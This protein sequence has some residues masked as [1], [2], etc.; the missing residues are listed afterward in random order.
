MKHVGQ[1]HN[2][3]EGPHK[4]QGA[5]KYAAE[6]HEEGLLHGVIVS[7][8]IAKGTIR[9]IDDSKAAKVPGVVKI[10]TH[11]NRPSLAWFDRS[12][13]DQDSPKG[14]HFRPLYD[15]KILFNAQPIALVVAENFEVARYAATLLH[16]E[17]ETAEHVTDLEA[18]RPNAKDPGKAKQGYVPPPKPKGD[19][20]KAWKSAP[21]KMKGSYVCPPEHHNPMEL[22]ATTVLVDKEGKYTVYD[23]TQGVTNS[24]DYVCNVFGLSKKE[25]RVLCPYMGGGFGSGLRPQYQLFLAIMAAKEL[26]QS[27]RVSMTRQQMFSFGHRPETHFHIALATDKNG[28]LLA[29]EQKALAETSTFET[30]AENLV[31]WPTL[32]YKCD[33][34][35]LEHKIAELDVFTPLDMRAPG[36]AWSL[37]VFEMAMDEMAYEAEI[38][39]IELRLANYT[40]KDENEKKPYTSKN[41]R[42][43]YSEGAKRFGWH[44]RNPYPRSMKRNGQLVGYGMATGAWDSEQQKAAIKVLLKQDGTAEVSSG[45]TD[46]GTGT[47]TIMTQIA[48]DNLGLKMAD[49]KF[50]LGDS[51]LPGAPLQGGSWTAASVGSAVEAGCQDARAKLSKLLGK[52]DDKD[53]KKAK[54][55]DLEIAEGKIKLIKNPRKSISVKELMTQTKTDKIEIETSKMPNLINAKLYTRKTHSAYFVEVE[56]DPD[57]GTVRVTRVVAS[58]AAGKILNPKTAR[59]QVLGGVVWGISMALQEETLMDHNLGRFMNHSFAEYHIP[60]NAD[61]HDIEVIFIPE[62]DSKVNPLGIKGLG[63]IGIVGVAAAVGNAIYHAT[64]HRVR[65]FPIT[66]DKVLEGLY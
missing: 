16:V 62:E 23:K 11:L 21:H 15:D 57:V 49:V 33:N 28:K 34:V 64:G 30:Y 17:Y 29:L 65:E 59:S 36:A 56:V 10:I 20:Q 27:V 22:F 39:Q 42:E 18:Q 52:L 45:V 9:A 14:A 43:C 3:V 46:I 54:P 40:E 8:A 12:Y 44:E 53:W 25:V 61:I 51:E 63:E 58:V 19:S 2:R 7:G 60:V 50:I 55:D 32:L 13:K 35:T 24:H 66:M 48:A 37:N 41:L 26:K 5:A 6:Y 31:N 4:V 47:Y 38:D 1:G